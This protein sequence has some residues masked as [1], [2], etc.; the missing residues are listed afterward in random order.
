MPLKLWKRSGREPKEDKGGSWD[1]GGTPWLRSDG[2]GGS[3]FPN[4]WA[5]DQVDSGRKHC[6]AITNI[7][8]TIKIG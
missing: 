4:L 8:R 7:H 6:S 2:V 5:E 1:P 3:G